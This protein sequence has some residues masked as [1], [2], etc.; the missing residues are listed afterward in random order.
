MEVGSGLTPKIDNYLATL[1][2]AEKRIGG[3]ALDRLPDA[4]LGLYNYRGVHLGHPE[5]D[6][7]L[8]GKVVPGNINSQLSAE[9]HNLGGFSDISPFTSWTDNP[10]I[11]RYFAG[12]DGIILRVPTG[13][14]K[15]GDNWSWKIS[16]DEYLEREILLK[17][18]RS[19][20]VEVFLP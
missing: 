8:N 10:N 7:A 11:A 5:W 2:G 14:P 4:E 9:E 3:T 12:D 15:S 20:D 6:N 13:S 16:M 19:G 18:P 17:G 1:A